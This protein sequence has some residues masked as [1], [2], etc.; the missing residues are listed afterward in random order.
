MSDPFDHKR[1]PSVALALGLGGLVPFGAGVLLLWFPE[2]LP[3][4]GSSFLV[5]Y[6][7]IILTFLGGIRWGT[8]IGPYD[9]KRQTIE[10]AG[11]VV[12]SLAGF[13][14]LLL[15]SILAFTLLIA[16]FLIQA[17]WD[18]TSV[19]AGR[20]PVWFGKLRMMLTSGAV[21]ALVLGLIAV[22]IT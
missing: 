22:A 17:L 7:A 18:V 6:G 3:G 15:P 13:V 9:G 21:L 2:L 1:I 8:A 11:S 14:A 5:G 16:G 10:F 12:G 19:E 4:L 20:L